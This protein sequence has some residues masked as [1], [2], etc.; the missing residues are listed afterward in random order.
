MSPP[1]DIPGVAEAVARVR[2]YHRRTKHMPGRYAPGPGYMDRAN[3]PDRFRRFLGARMVELPLVPDDD[4][5]PTT[6]RSSLKG[7]RLGR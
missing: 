1:I 4:T 7:R 3:Q 5:P 2:A 6:R